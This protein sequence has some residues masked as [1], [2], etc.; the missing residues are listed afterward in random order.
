MTAADPALALAVAPDL[1]RQVF[2]KIGW[3][4]LPV[5]TLA[6]LVNYLDRTNIAFAGL[7]MN[8][9]LGLT[10]SQFGLGAGVLF[11]GYCGFGLPANILMYR[12]GP[13]RWIS[14]LLVVWGII[15]AGQ[16][17]AKGPLSF[18]LAR[19][20]LGAAEA[21]FFPAVAFYLGNWFPAQY[22]ARIIAWFMVA[23][24][25]SSVIGGPVSGSLLGLNGVA[26][27]AG[28]KWMFLVEAAP[29][30]ILGVVLLFR[31]RD[32][33]Q[34]ALWLTP[35]ERAT[36]VACLAGEKRD[37]PVGGL[38]DALRD[39]RVLLCAGLQLGFVIGAY[40][41]G[42]WL[43]L[44][45]KES[46]LSNFVIGWLTA[47]PYI[48]ASV[49][50]IIWAAHVDRTGKKIDNLIAAC[51]VAAVGFVLVVATGYWQLS[52]VGFSIAL[53]GANAARGI[54]WTVPTRFLTGIAAAGGLAFINTIGTMGGF[55]GPSIIGW[56]KDATGG[57]TA[58][59]VA[60]AGFLVMAVVFGF[61]LKRVVREE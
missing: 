43:P 30:C 61:I 20:L 18:C 31:L 19:F 48:C 37:R 23:I 45:L 38:M 58:G 16:I 9:D 56:L 26:G 1:E 7:T 2:R 25:L 41:V 60:M 8:H 44:M 33:P 49:A 53:V 47:I 42:F 24:P 51:L 4:L 27:L 35:E 6:Y 10:A 32:R 12:F 55:L 13:R 22:R 28:W 54:F 34:D 29:A 52:L 39:V 14:G 40:G 50:M 57:Y 17:L 5:L 15:S 36:A 46:H 21:G 59:L 11:V 3:R